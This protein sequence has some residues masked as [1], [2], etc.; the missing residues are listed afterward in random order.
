VV[1]VDEIH[2]DYSGNVEDEF[3]PG[4]KVQLIRRFVRKH[5]TSEVVRLSD[6]DKAWAAAP[7]NDYQRRQASLNVR[8]KG[9]VAFQLPAEGEVLEFKRGTPT[10]VLL[11]GSVSV[12]SNWE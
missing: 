12:E 10:L 7:I 1:I 2:V 4:D 3:G 5:L 8:T 11:L 6:I 9:E